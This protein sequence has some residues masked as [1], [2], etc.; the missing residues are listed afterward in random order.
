MCYLFCDVEGLAVGLLVEPHAAVS[1][2]NNGIVRLLQP[3]WI[4]N[5][6]GMILVEF[7][8]HVYSLK[9]ISNKPLRNVYAPDLWLFVKSRDV[10]L[11]HLLHAV[12]GVL[13]D[14]SP[15]N[16]TNLD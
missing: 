3:L 4:K 2:S 11:H 7:R 13:F 12:V 16:E 5:Q 9:L 8:K 1:L 15:E 6:H 10:P 14:R